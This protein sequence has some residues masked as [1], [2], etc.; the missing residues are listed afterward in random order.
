MPGNQSSRTNTPTA[1]SEQNAGAT[2]QQP[3][4]PPAQP[5]DGPEPAKP[6]SVGGG[7]ISAV[8]DSSL[9]AP[10]GAPPLNAADVAATVA[11][12]KQQPSPSEYV[13]GEQDVLTITVWK[14]REL[15]GSVVVRP[16]GKITLPLVDDIQ[17][18]GL[19]PAQLRAFLI[20]KLKP[21][22]SIPQ[23]TVAV[24]QI[25]SRKVYLIGEV[26]KTGTFP[27]N[28]STTVLQILAQAG[29]LKDYA[30]RK[31]IYV[32]RNQEGKQVRYRFNYDEVIRGQNS[33]QNILLQPADTVVVP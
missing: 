10:T 25:N 11:R 1:S 8:A 22:V 32:L 26:S 28:S 18:V 17:V 9:V 19:T 14:E 4:N 20:E 16:D 6:S 24:T 2:I 30:K 5:N 27:I 33:Q 12:A 31:D 13:I 7:P 21:F 15:S 3:V 29:G 23:V